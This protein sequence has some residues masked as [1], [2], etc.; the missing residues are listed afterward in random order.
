VNALLTEGAVT[1]DRLARD[2]SLVQ[3]AG[4]LSLAAVTVGND[5]GPTHLAAAVGCP[6]VAVFGPTDPVVWAPVGSRVS[7]LGGPSSG[8]RWPEVAPV[9]SALRALFARQHVAVAPAP[10]GVS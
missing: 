10:A 2:W 5:S 7:I 1:E 9:E 3:I 4:L 8:T 6:T